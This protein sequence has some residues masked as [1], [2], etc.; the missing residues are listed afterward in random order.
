MVRYY[1]PSL[2]MFIASSATAF[3]PS[4]G[5]TK[6]VNSRPNSALS[7]VLTLYGSPG[8][9]SPLVNWAANELGLSLESGDLSQNPH[10]FGQI[11]CLTDDNDV[12]VFESGAIL[13][14]LQSK[15]AKKG[16]YDDKKLAAVTSW[17]VSRYQAL[18]CIFMHTCVHASVNVV[19]HSCP[20]L[21]NII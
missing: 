16:I 6:P 14:Y 12:L 11:P 5:L 3:S 2:L 8:S 17:I 10:P 9:R 13:N 15:A 18:L 7:M 21:L 1:V 4:N 19:A 20:Y